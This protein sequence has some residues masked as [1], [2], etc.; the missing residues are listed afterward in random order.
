MPE[1]KL[2]PEWVEYENRV[3]ELERR[4]IED[5]QFMSRLAQQR[6][7]EID[8]LILR[9]RQLELDLVEEQH[10]A[11]MMIGKV[12]KRVRQLEA[13]LKAVKLRAETGLFTQQITHMIS[14]VLER[15]ND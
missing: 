12:N 1:I 13:T 7:H 15:K 3:V 9:V 4:R 11:S 14:G 10:R 5:V 6:Q 2:P 8:E